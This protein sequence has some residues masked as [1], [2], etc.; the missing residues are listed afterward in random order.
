VC[1]ESEW[2]RGLMGSLVDFYFWLQRICEFSL[3]VVSGCLVS[4]EFVDGCET[5]FL[6]QGR[7]G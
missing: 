3:V 4:L 5:Y 7:G 2:V 1:C 6:L